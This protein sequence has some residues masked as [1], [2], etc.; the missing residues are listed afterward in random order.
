VLNGVSCTG[1][2]SCIA[3]GS[4]GISGSSGATVLLAE[5]WDGARW[6]IQAVPSPAGAAPGLSGVSCASGSACTAVGSSLLDAGDGP[7][8][9][10]AEAW[11]GSRWTFQ[12]TPSLART[13]Q[14][15]LGGVSCTPGGPCIAVGYSSGILG[16]QSPLALVSA[17]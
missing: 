15:G 8:V 16:L 6:S 1:A 3:V 5:R 9:A 2:D 4:Y 13:T 17:G 10:F 7:S 11:N 14:S 12:A